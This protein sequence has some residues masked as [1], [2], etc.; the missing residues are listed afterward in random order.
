MEY[1]NSRVAG[2]TRGPIVC[3]E[4]EKEEYPKHSNLLLIRLD[5]LLSHLSDVKLRLRESVFS[6]TYPREQ[7]T[8]D[9]PREKEGG[10][11]DIF[12]NKFETELNRLENLIK[13][14][15]GVAYSLEGF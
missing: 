7:P 12:V 8:N 15:E 13:E 10:K 3:T 4:K 14:L 1:S 2:G 6:I 11:N 5:S 9:P